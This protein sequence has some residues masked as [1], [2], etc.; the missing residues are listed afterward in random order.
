V[1]IARPR[2]LKSFRDMSKTAVGLVS[3]G[4]IAAACVATFAVG[5]L[6]LLEDRYSMS[7]VFSDTGGLRSG[8][9][10]RVAGVDVGEVT[11]VNPNF[12][13]GHVVI[14]WEVDRNV[15]LGRDTTAE[16]ALGTLLGGEHLRLT[17]TPTE[18]FLADLPAEE[19][20]I[21]LDR[22]SVPISVAEALGD[23]TRAVQELDT[24]RVNDVISSFADV[25][26]ES[27][28]VAGD[29]FAHLDAVASAITER[30]ADV[31]R[32]VDS[33]RTVTAT[34]AERDQQ[35][36]ALVDAAAVLLDQIAQR[37]DQL[38]AVLGDGAA[39]VQALSTT[40]AEHRQSLEAVLGDLHV[41][42]DAAG[43]QLGPLNESLAWMGP[44]FSGLSR[45]GSHGPWIDVMF[46]ALGPDVLG[47]L[48]Q[49]VADAQA[50]QG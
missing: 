38:A 34:L 1:R 39:A 16:I 15:E 44:T 50:A 14:T 23:T 28:S 31:Q 2:A 7:G 48:R 18:P 47:V 12:Q 49:L 29:L 41:A 13:E 9:A 25:A 5:Q 11:G 10:V 45:A 26:T 22:T 37:R 3:V 24:D 40:L 8:D 20:R 6:G 43:R 35:L 17:S 36:V 32:L 27:Q 42:I 46:E 21:P 33:S 19:R 30:E 4:L